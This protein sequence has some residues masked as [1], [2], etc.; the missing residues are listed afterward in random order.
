MARKNYYKVIELMRYYK[1]EFDFNRVS[2]LLSFLAELIERAKLKCKLEKD[3]MVYL[4]L[5]KSS[6]R[7]LICYQT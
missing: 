3:P 6:K 5:W 4:F 1:E 7:K 2:K